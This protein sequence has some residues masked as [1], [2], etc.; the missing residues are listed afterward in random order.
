GIVALIESR[1]DHGVRPRTDTRLAGVGLRA[2][3]GVAARAAVRLVGIGARAARRIA[4]AGVVALIAS[5]AY[6]GGR[7]H[8]D[9]GLGAVGLVAGPPV[10]AGLAVRL[11]GVGPCPSPPLS[12]PGVVALIEGGAGHGVRPRADTRLA[13]VGLRAGIAVVAG[14][15]VRP[16]RV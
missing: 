9:T 3:V 10:V 2:G 15:A 7:P 5:A 13:G 4:D 12:R 14:A 11:V 1:A 6:D 8:A 16:V